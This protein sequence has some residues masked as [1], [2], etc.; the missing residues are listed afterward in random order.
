MKLSAIAG[1]A[2]VVLFA[3]VAGAQQPRPPA[4]QID[5]GLSSPPVTPELWIYSQEVQRHDDPAQAVRRKAE[6]K[7]D[8]RLNRL[9]ALKWYGQ[10][11][12]R[13]ETSPIPVMGT[14]SPA[15]AGNGSSRYDWA[16]V[17]GPSLTLRYDV[18]ELRR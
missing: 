15:W 7:A 9:A 8:Q 10:S 1:F 16:A 2:L 4:P 11:N 18:F 12:A 14:Y 13:P 17:G 3:G 5:R 6:I